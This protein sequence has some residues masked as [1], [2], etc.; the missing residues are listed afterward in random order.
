MK[1]IALILAIFAIGWWLTD[2]DR[3]IRLVLA[4]NGACICVE[5]HKWLC[6][7]DIKSPSSDDSEL[8]LQSKQRE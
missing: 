2:C 3:R 1:A 8:L 5:D 7:G 6:K 4:D